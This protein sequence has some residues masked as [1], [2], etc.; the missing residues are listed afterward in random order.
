MGRKYTITPEKRD[1]FV[2]DYEELG[3][4]RAL[5]KKWEVHHTTAA[6]ALRRF[7]LETRNRHDI[8]KGIYHEKLGLWP[9]VRVAK[10]LGVSRQAVAKARRRRGLESALDRA[11]R[12]VSEG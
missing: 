5:A 9:D 7:G 3:T 11:L 8:S 6:E 10:D 1:A 4:I 12:L 2:K